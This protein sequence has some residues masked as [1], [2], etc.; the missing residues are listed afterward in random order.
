[1]VRANTNYFTGVE[2][3]VN[4]GQGISNSLFPLYSD[5]SEVKKSA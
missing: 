2:N 1:M 5:D 4:R 3:H